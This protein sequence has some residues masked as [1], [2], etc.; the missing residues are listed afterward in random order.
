MRTITTSATLWTSCRDRLIAI[1]LLALA[2]LGT[3]CQ[4]SS[5]AGAHIIV[6]E[7][8][9]PYWVTGGMAFDGSVVGGVA[10]SLSPGEYDVNHNHTWQ[11]TEQAI[12]PLDIYHT[13]A[14][15]KDVGFKERFIEHRELTCDVLKHMS[16]S[17]RQLLWFIIDPD[18]SLRVVVLPA[19]RFDE[20]KSTG[21]RPL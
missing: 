6:V 7:N 9:S 18:L 8:R 11:I 14:A 17:N 20:I 4:R 16:R 12:V 2:L 21:Q 15:K 13:E 5:T 19:A 1:L 10:E 3:A